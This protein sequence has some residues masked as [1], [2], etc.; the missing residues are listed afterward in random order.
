MF[1]E[2][3][4]QLK[5]LAAAL[6]SVFK[7]DRRVLTADF[8]EALGLITCDGTLFSHPAKHRPVDRRRCGLFPS[9][10]KAASKGP[11]TETEVK[12][13]EHQASY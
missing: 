7:A 11:W 3:L 12:D 10:A 8:D 6:T 2:D 4:P 1:A 5:M 9:T 13:Q